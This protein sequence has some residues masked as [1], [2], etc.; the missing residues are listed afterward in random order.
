PLA[1]RRV[2]MASWLELGAGS[3]VST[4][5]DGALQITGDI[6]LRAEITPEDWTPT[7][8]QAI[9]GRWFTS[10]AAQRSYRI[11][12]LTNGRLRFTW[13]V[14]GQ[15]GAANIS[16]TVSVTPP[17]SGRLAVRATFDVNNGTSGRTIR[18]YTA[19]SIAGPWTQLGNPVTQ[20]GTTSIHPGTAPLTVGAYNAGASEPFVGRV[21][22][23]EVRA[24]IDGSLVAAV[25]FTQLAGGTTAFT[26][27]TGRNW[28]IA[29]NASI[30]AAPVITGEAES[31][32]TASGE[33]D[34][35]RR[36]VGT[37]A[38]AATASGEASGLRRVV[39]TAASEAGGPAVAAGVR[40]TAGE[41]ASSVTTASTATGAPVRGGTAT[42]SATATGEADGTR[43]V[44]GVA[45]SSVVTRGSA[46]VAVAEIGDGADVTVTESLLP[47]S[48][49]ESSGAVSVTPE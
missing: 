45:G 29:G 34:G 30:V 28:T 18:F 4:P 12:L 17:E 9:L 39:G 27:A 21:W 47:E 2:V 48:V 20:G 22:A 16:S 43:R 41:A 7:A 32:V 6:D 13:S 49:A 46:I 44:V 33:A 19:P 35:T 23:A 36:V 5:P 37:A 38:N 31:A 14:N 24:G 25:D 26:D 3:N 42:S 1:S 15:T 40:R 8:N 11:D 10:G